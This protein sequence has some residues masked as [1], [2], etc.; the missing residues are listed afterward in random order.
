MHS[1]P[2]RLHV[3]DHPMADETLLRRQSLLPIN[4]AAILKLRQAGISIS[5]GVQPVFQLMEWGIAS[6][7]RGRYQDIAHELEMLRLAPDQPAAL[8]YLLVH[9]PGGLKGFARTILLR[10]PRTAARAL[11]D[12]LDMRIKADPKK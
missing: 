4:Q 12:Q 6:D 10:D 1:L 8:D 2:D 11:L 5:S 9:V 7:K 3:I